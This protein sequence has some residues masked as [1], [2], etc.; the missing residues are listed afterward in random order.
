MRRLCILALLA[1]TCAW[2]AERP[3]LG[4]VIIVDQLSA[5][6]F[7]ADA[8][9]F[10]AGLKRLMRDGTTF[11]EARFPAAPTVTSVGHATLITGCTGDTQAVSKKV[12]R[13]V[14]FVTNLSFVTNGVLRGSFSEL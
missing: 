3:R 8:P 9:H 14:P 13:N 7:R 11:D 10:K 12:P 4:V 5:E 6:A 2:A 1:G